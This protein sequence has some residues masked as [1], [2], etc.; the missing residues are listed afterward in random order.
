MGAVWTEALQDTPEDLWVYLP[1]FG[2]TFISGQTTG[3]FAVWMF[4]EEN[5]WF[6]TNKVF[7]PYVWSHSTGEWYFVD[8]RFGTNEGIRIIRLSDNEVVE[9]LRQ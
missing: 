1:A 8:M 4:N 2:W 5:G 6:F 9:N 3:P 7:Y